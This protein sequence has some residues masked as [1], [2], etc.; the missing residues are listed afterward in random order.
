VEWCGGVERGNKFFELANHLGNVLVVVS[1]RKIGVANASGVITSWTAQVLDAQDYAPFG[2]VMPGRKFSANIVYGGA[3]APQRYRY[4]FNGKENM[5]GEYYAGTLAGTMQDYGMRIYDPRLGRFLSVDPLTKEYPELTPYQYA[6]NS[7]VVLIDID[8]EE[9]AYKLPDG[10]IYIHPP[11]DHLRIPVPTWIQH[12]GELIGIGK[13][14][15][16]SDLSLA[17]DVIPIVGTVKGWIEVAVGEDLITG[18]QMSFGERALGLIPGAKIA[19][20]VK[21]AAKLTV[22]TTKLVF[23]SAQ[24]GLRIF[25]KAIHY[26]KFQKLVTDYGAKIA[27]TIMD[28]GRLGGTNVLRGALERA[29]KGLAEAWQAHHIIPVELIEKNPLVRKAIDEGFDF[30]G[31]INGI[32]VAATRHTGRHPKEYVQAIE[33]MIVEAQKTMTGKS[34]KEIMESVAKQAADI[35]NAAE[36]QAKKI[37]EIF[38]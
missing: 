4:G 17:L 33:T 5:D 12:N 14:G 27:T 21:V 31:T 11:S 19:K 15:D 28:A 18:A 37:N 20:G 35:I 3:N 34:A 6:S 9:G 8:G 24:F 2:M 1:D 30:N 26:Q 36:N 32:A 29:K 7:P 10:S 22:V 16:G 38:K 23:K 13:A 25:A